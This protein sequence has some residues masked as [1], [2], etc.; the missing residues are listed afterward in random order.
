MT[1]ALRG[2]RGATTA[3]SN[4]GD[5]MLDA[6]RELLSR[7]VEANGIDVDDIASVVFSTT[8]DLNADFPAA[9]ARSLGWHRVPMLCTH[10]MDVPGALPRCIRVLLHWNTERGSADVR[11]VYLHDARRLRPDLVDDPRSDSGDSTPAALAGETVAVVGLGLI[12]GSMGAA[13]RR[14]GARVV[15]V[16]ASPG[17]GARALARG[18]VDELAPSPA[19]ACAGATIVVLAAPVAVLPGLVAEVGRSAG[20]GALVLDTGSVKRPVVAAM[21]ALPERVR[22]VAGHPMA[23]SERSGPDAARADLFAGATFA[24]CRTAR[25]DEGGAARAEGF[26]RAVGARPVWLDAAAHDRL[27]APVSHVPYL[28]SVAL[29]RAVA[30]EGPDAWALAASGF[31][32]ASRLA[33]GEPVMMGD[34]LRGNA[35]EVR[36]SAAAVTRELDAL[37]R[38]LDDGEAL[39]RALGEA[40]EERRDWA[41]RKDRGE[42]GEMPPSQDPG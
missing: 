41:E 23:G 38:S 8:A 20:E 12:G 9:A 16:D 42:G 11:H 30:R 33:A 34:I 3:A 6:T 7:L 24:L 32:D 10:E 39:R 27:A 37:L 31:R 35:D 4:T 2:V 1:L 19:A 14:A 13:A 22:A 36:R 29:V 15:G 17:T 18:L 25:T 28:L 40:A 26:V 21:D 5:A